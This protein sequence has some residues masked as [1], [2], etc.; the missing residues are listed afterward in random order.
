M[1]LETSL[2]PPTKYVHRYWQ[3]NDHK[4]NKI[5]ELHCQN[6]FLRK[7]VLYISV[8]VYVPS[9]TSFIIEC[10]LFTDLSPDDMTPKNPTYKKKNYL[11]RTFIFFYFVFLYHVIC[12]VTTLYRTK[13]PYFRSDKGLTEGGKWVSTVYSTS[14]KPTIRKHTK[15]NQDLRRKKEQT[16]WNWP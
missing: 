13:D 6:P 15:E 4:K 3:C 16:D 2:A 5:V 8:V 14:P 1:N 11:W 7:R 9:R 10:K 12:N